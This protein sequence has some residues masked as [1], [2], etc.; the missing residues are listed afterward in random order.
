MFYFIISSIYN[1]QEKTYY[2]DKDNYITEDAIVDNLIYDKEGNCLVFW[3]S[4]IDEAYESSDFIIKGRNL[5]VVLEKG[6]VE[7]IDVGSKITYTSAP[8]YFGN[9]Y[10]MPIVAISVAGE[11][12][13]SFD[14]GYENL[15]KSY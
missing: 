6:V 14:E 4:E 15:I 3:L 13:L 9:G 10:F 11:E 7:K 8:G 1:Y 5:S 2:L 12:L